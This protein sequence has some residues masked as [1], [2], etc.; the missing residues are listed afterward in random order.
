M[1]TN[2]SL[3]RFEQVDKEYEYNLIESSQDDFDDSFE[4][5]LL[6]VSDLEGG[7]ASRARFVDSFGSAMEEVGFALLVNH[8]LDLSLLRSVESVALELFTSTPDEEKLKF[9]ATKC[10]WGG[11]LR[12]GYFPILEST[13]MQPNALEA[14]EFCREDFRLSSDSNQRLSPSWPN[15][16]LE[17]SLRPYWQGCESL[18][19]P[20][21][22]SILEYLDADPSLYD[23]ELSP[24]NGLLRLNHYPP[25]IE[26]AETTAS[27]FMAHED[28]GLFTLLPANTIEGLQIFHPQRKAWSRLRP[29]EGSIIVNAGDWLKLLSNNRL[30][31]CTHRV[32]VPQDPAQ[33]SRSRISTPYVVLPHESSTLEVLPGL[34]PKYQP[35]SAMD[36][37]TGLAG[38]IVKYDSE[39]LT[40]S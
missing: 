10:A 35:V 33:R 25:V 18:V 7:D 27:R 3:S 30:H 23:A 4:L 1:T 31:S 29:P 19:L 40:T 8:G 22:R 38:K 26:T 14:W 36:F 39:R 15:D 12:R 2:K 5:Q 16:R 28:Y 11:A 20:L 13:S 24:P 32:A 37:M 9:L 21:M 34:T 6:D 17:R